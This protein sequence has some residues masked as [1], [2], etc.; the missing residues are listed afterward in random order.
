M[1][2]THMAER[3]DRTMTDTYYR[4]AFGQ[5][6]PVATIPEPVPTVERIPRTVD[7]STWYAYS[8]ANGQRI[9]ATSRTRKGALAQF[10]EQWARFAR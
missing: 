9:G 4:Q 5:A 2:R 1:H 10:S 7:G 3:E 6:A 8:D